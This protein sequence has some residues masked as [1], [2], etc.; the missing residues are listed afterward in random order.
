MSE[1]RFEEVYK[2]GKLTAEKIIRDNKTGVLYLVYQEGYGMG[3]TVM[4]DKDGKP[5]VDESFK[6]E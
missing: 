1:K 4:V 5:L 6:D 3:L 2:Q